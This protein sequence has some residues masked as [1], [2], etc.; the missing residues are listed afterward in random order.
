LLVTENRPF[1]GSEDF[2]D[3]FTPDAP[4]TKA[5]ERVHVFKL[6][7]EWVASSPWTAQKD[8]ELKQ[9][10]ADLTRRGIAIAFEAGPLTATS[11]CGAGIEGFAGPEEGLRIAR[12][13]KA[14]GGE[15][16]FVALD[17]PF[18][19]AS[20]YD[21]PNACR[22]PPEKVA[23]EVNGYIEAIKGVFPDVIIGDTEVLW[24]TMDVDDLKHWL[25]AY[26]SV[27]GSQLPFFHLDV[28]Y[29]RPDWP[30]AAK[31]LES[32]AR[33][34]GIEF[35]IIYTGNWKDPSDEAWLANAGER[36]KTYELAYGGRPDHIL[37]QSW[38]DHPDYV[39]PET[40]PNTFTN[41]IDL[42]FEDRAALGFRTEGP[43]ANLAL[44]GQ[45]TASSSLPD[46]QPAMAV[47]G[48]PDNWWGSGDLAPQWIELDLGAPASIGQIR[49][50]ISQDPEGETVHRVWGKGP[51]EDYQLLHEFRGL[52]KDSQVLEHTPPTLW[53]GIQFV[54]VETVESPSWVSWRE[55]EIIAPRE[56][57]SS[58]GNI[59]GGQ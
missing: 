47:D 30:E 52:T 26:Y 45:V 7:G 36:V 43:G 23:R 50:T 12:R 25:D 59:T 44:G 29:T 38:H 11:T 57:Q 5:A 46:L 58:S 16:R 51:G 4:W 27:T 10:V 3:L 28:D 14:A 35:G 17:E 32:F 56:S 13:I 20:I 41:F 21:G 54:K 15:V 22:W 6:Y 33:E 2:M 42:Y 48:N 24:A 18:A 31:E 55:I 34:R 1:I 39:L 19:F 8:A 49:L 37:F 9:V 53:L 40:E